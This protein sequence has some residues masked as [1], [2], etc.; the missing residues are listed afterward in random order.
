MLNRLLGFQVRLQIL[1]LGIQRS[2]PSLLIAAALVST[3][4]ML[5][6]YPE[7]V[8]GNWWVWKAVGRSGQGCLAWALQP[9][10]EVLVGLN[11]GTCCC[12]KWHQ[13]SW[14]EMM[15]SR[16][17][18]GFPLDGLYVCNCSWSYA[19][20]DSFWSF[21]SPVL[22]QSEGMSSFGC[23][24]ST[25]STLFSVMC[26]SKNKVLFLACFNLEILVISN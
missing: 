10:G 20:P 25:L 26:L 15:M 3:W 17:F 5:W 19:S 8:R 16:Y 14:E 21:H 12:C 23:G 18:L 6:L 9:D 11:P 1:V 22:V 7:L 2:R 13:R 24:C 4:L